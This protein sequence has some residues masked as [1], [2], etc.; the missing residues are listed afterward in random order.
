LLAELFVCDMTTAVATCDVCGRS[1]PLG[2]LP[3]YGKEM[4]AV[5]RCPGCDGLLVAMTRLN[6]VIRLDLRGVRV[7]S[8]VPGP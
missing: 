4:G 3:L 7:L 5:L 6:G 2:A 8:V 1:T